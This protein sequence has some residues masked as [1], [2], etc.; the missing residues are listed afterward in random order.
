[1]IL[2]QCSNVVIHG[3]SGAVLTSSSAAPASST[4]GLV[5]GLSN[6]FLAGIGWS[7]P[8][9]MFDGWESWE[10]FLWGRLDPKVFGF[11]SHMSDHQKTSLGSWFFHVFLMFLFGPH[12]RLWS[13][14]TTSLA[15]VQLAVRLAVLPVVLPVA[16]AAGRHRPVA[17]GTLVDMWWFITIITWFTRRVERHLRAVVQHEG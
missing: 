2:G 8:R 16:V 9:S 12:H 3:I 17:A 6:T 15:A 4:T 1:M 13:L 11:T 7:G 5:L 14:T 10:L